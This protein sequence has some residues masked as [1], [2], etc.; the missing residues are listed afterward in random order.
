[1]YIAMVHNM[2]EVEKQPNKIMSS[3]NDML[4][5]FETP[6]LKRHKR[7]GNKIGVL[8]YRFDARGDYR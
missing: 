6:P 3:S 7:E 8:P 4:T 5:G 2:F 1:M